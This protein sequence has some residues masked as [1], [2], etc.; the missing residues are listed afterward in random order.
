MKSKLEHFIP[1]NS[2]NL[3]QSIIKNHHFHFKITKHRS[4]KF[5]DYRFDS[6][7]NK[8]TITV[9]GTLN[10][11][12]FLIT[13]LHEV[14]HLKVKL[15]YK[16]RGIK[17]H[18][19]EWKKEFA[20]LLKQSIELQ[21]YPVDIENALLKYMKNPKASSAND[22]DLYQSLRRYDDGAQQTL[23]KDIEEGG[24]F[25]FRKKQYRKITKRRTRSLCEQ[26]GTGRRY[27]ISE[28]AEV[29]KLEA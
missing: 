28:I 2:L 23:L 6:R 19:P 4:S 5:G 20:M 9:N 3:V 29:D 16:S 24:F 27:L 7:T 11:Y 8:H 26:L 1:P 10:T 13:F 15:N 22:Q 14:A 17:P 12:S 18:G 21:C 25:L